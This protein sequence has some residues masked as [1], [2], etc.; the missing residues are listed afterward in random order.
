[1]KILF[2]FLQVTA[3][4]SGNNQHYQKPVN[5]IKKL[6]ATIESLLQAIRSDNF[7]VPSVFL[8]STNDKQRPRRIKLANDNFRNAKEKLGTVKD[9]I[10]WDTLR[11]VHDDMRTM[12]I[13]MILT[14]T[15]P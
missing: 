4:F 9:M 5:S 1:M 15:N 7:K 12:D 2:I 14:T 13:S 8:D 3:T 6:P 10:S 11:Y